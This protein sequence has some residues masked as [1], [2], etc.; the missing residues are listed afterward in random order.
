MTQQ[1]HTWVPKRK[2]THVHTKICMGMF[3]ANFF[4]I[5]PNWKQVK[6]SSQKNKQIV[7]YPKME[8][9]SVIKNEQIS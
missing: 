2:K 7:V 1:F 6:C 3:T 5:A 4:T 8:Y 9:Y